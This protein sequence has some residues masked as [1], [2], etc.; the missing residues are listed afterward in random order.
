MCV[1]FT[2][3]TYFYY[4]GCCCEGNNDTFDFSYGKISLYF[5]TIR[6]SN[7]LELIA[8]ENRGITVVKKYM[9]HNT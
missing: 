6:F 2:S 5:R 8:Y 9:M 1:P 7:S 3:F 4:W